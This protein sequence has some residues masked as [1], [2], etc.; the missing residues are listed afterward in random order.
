VSPSATST[1][2]AAE[3]QAFE[4]ATAVV[5]AYR[6][7]I[8]DLYSGARTDLND[9]N[10]VATGELLDKG[11]MNIQQ[12]LGEGWSVVPSGVQVAIVSSALLRS[13]LESDPNRVE[14]RACLDAS[15]VTEID[16]QG[17]RRPGVRE[18][19]DYTIIRTSYLPAPGWA[20]SEV[21]TDSDDIE[22][23]R[24]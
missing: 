13:D 24:C 12:S 2:S 14:L 1:L 20:V 5:L 19:L 8:T 7:T 9:L 10:D 22:D 11:L 3:Q 21:S 23:R 15:D 16:P 4:E 6:Q 18:Q 17:G